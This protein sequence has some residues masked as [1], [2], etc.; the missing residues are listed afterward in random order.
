MN[1]YSPERDC[2]KRKRWVGV[3]CEFEFGRKKANAR[4]VRRSEK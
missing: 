4:V 2:E 3:P 1:D